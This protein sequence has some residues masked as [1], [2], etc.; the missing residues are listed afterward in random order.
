MS[1]KVNVAKRFIGILLMVSLVLTFSVVSLSEGKTNI[2]EEVL[3]NKT[4]GDTSA[5]ITIAKAQES[6]STYA[7]TKSKELAEREKK[8]KKARARAKKKK[9][10]QEKKK[11]RA[12]ARAEKK[13]KIKARKKVKAIKKAAKRKGSHIT[14]A[15]EEVLSKEDRLKKQQKII[16][17]QK[18]KEKKIEKARLKKEKAEQKVLLAEQRRIEAKAEKEARLQ[19]LK[20]EKQIK[21]EQKK[22]RSERK[23]EEN[24]KKKAERKVRIEETRARKEE[25]AIEQ[26]RLQTERAAKRKIERETRL[27]REEEEKARRAIERQALLKKQAEERAKKEAELKIKREAERKEREI[28]LAEQKRLQAEKDARRKVEREA[29]LKR[30]EEERARRAIERQALLEKQAEAKAKKEAELK[31]KRE[32]KRKQK[33]A[34]LV[35]R[36]RLQAEKEAIHKAKKDA[37]IKRKQ[38]RLAEKERIKYEKESKKRAKREAK[39]KEKEEKRQRKIEERNARREKK[40]GKT[41]IGSI[42]EK[43]GKHKKPDSQ[44]RD[45]S[46]I[47]QEMMEDSASSMPAIQYEMT[48]GDCIS[49]AME[50]HLPLDIAEKQLRLAKFRL[51]EAKRKLGPSITFKWEQS[52]GIISSKSYTGEK[53]SVEGKQPIFYGG[54]LVF[55]VSQAKV[56]LEIVENDYERIR[57]DLILQVRKAY[58]SLDKSKKAFKVQKK[59]GVKTEKFYQIA[60]HSYEAEVISQLEFLK[61][62]SQYNQSN[63]QMMSAEEDLSVANLLLQQAMNLDTE[64]YI[65][66]LEHPRVIELALNR[67]FDLAYLNRPEMKINQLSLEYF[68]YERKIMQARSNFPRVDLLGMYGNTREDFMERELLGR[69]PRGLGPEFYVGTK[70]SVPVWGST[71]GYSLTNE[72]WQP[73]VSTTRGTRSTTHT[74]TLDLLNKLEDISAVKEADLEYMRSKEEMNKKKQEISLEV[75]ENFFKYKKS[76]LL[77]NVAKSKVE[78]QAKQVDVLDIRRE[79]GEAQYSDVI[80]EMIKLAEEE[81]SYIQAVTDYYIAI[82]SLN[83]A[84]GLNNYFQI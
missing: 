40:K 58:Y 12:K 9:Q 61:V 27:K 51:F 60:K 19:N 84:I 57:N 42:L 18:A 54:E 46:A 56:N 72:D 79:L 53:V 6:V 70:I 35:E 22:A 25:R 14:V 17:E 81:F 43:F 28:L 1:G 2:G 5:R 41:L 67:C 4:T 39:L 82:A 66:D 76:I 75:K 59:L 44:S 21:A 11:K 49:V 48:L 77:M 31:I 50:N 78:F 65:R 37:K 26:K 10:L 62:A 83:K 47:S 73:V 8:N 16:A 74:T 38:E 15:T 30:E 7:Q 52:G 34:L 29:R 80:E 20:E 23:R 64:V 71:V 24:L 36:K 32:T 3:Y 68:D 63:F 69:D 33:E 13:R 45:T 55:S